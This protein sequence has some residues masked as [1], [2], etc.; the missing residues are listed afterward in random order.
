M[1]LFPNQVTYIIPVDVFGEKIE[2][3]QIH[4]SHERGTCPGLPKV[5]S[6]Q[7]S[8][9]ESSLCELYIK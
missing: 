3:F 2:K 6:K 1:Y 4:S 7:S 8:V 5:S 9:L